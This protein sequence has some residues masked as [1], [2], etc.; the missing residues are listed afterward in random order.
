MP[1]YQLSR[2]GTWDYPTLGFRATN[3]DILIGSAAPDAFWLLVADG[4]AETVVRY[5]VG[6]GTPAYTE[7]VD[8]TLL[9]WNPTSK[10]FEQTTAA[11]YF[12]KTAPKAALNTG[13]AQVLTPIVGEAPAD[14][15]ARINAALAATSPFGTRKTVRLVGNFTI[16]GALVVPSNT[17]LDVLGATITASASHVGC[18]IRNAGA[19]PVATGTGSIAAGSQTLTTSLNLNV[20]QTVTIAGADG[21]GTTVHTGTITAVGAGSVTIDAAAK[22]TVAGATVLVFNRDSDVR[23]LHGQWNR[24][25]AA[26]TGTAPG[27]F[28]NIYLRHVD[29]WT[30]DI[31]GLSSTAAKYALSVGSATRGRVLLRGLQANSDGC[32][33]IGPA[34][35]IHVEL[36]QGST[37]DDVFAITAADWV[38]YGDTAGDVRNIT[39]GNIFGTSNAALF[40]V[41]SGSGYHVDGVKVLGEITGTA[42][43][44]GVYI[45]DDTGQ[46]ST[47]GGTYGDIDFGTL[48]ATA[49]NQLVVVN[50]M[51]SGESVRG[52]VVWKYGAGRL[53]RALRVYAPNS[54]TGSTAKRLKLL[55]LDVNID[56]TGTVDSTS[57]PNAV[58]LFT[59]D[60][61]NYT[62]DTIRLR[63]RFAANAIGGVAVNHNEGNV[64]EYIWELDALWQST[65]ATYGLRWY[66]GTISRLTAPRGSVVGGNVLLRREGAGPTSTLQVVLGSAFRASAMSRVL[67]VRTGTTAVRMDNPLFDSLLNA[68]IF[69]NGG[70]LD[71]DGRYA[72]VGSAALL[73]QGG[74]A[75]IRARS[76]ALDL[77][78]ATTGL[79]KNNGDMANNTNAGLSCG[80]GPA[81]SNGTAWKN[82]YSGAT[83]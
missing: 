37:G 77:D 44:N 18:L 19:F 38:A 67:D 27:R 10:A 83:Y 22:S 56:T 41:I 69:T 62:V 55:D 59:K 2:A 82:L 13:Y 8:G 50:G 46:P 60:G 29:D 57:T 81:V 25:S 71:L 66:L 72:K 21:A 32:H 53:D 31:A 76:A 79:A 12:A 15:T 65:T 3:G 20:G 51:D 24:G 11:A 5:G 4:P 47:T 64:G 52:R 78:L 80:A 7:P 74:T 33:I 40:K 70:I 75:A 45:G 39:I 14:T 6:S 48:N 34:R 42:R 35:D 28:H 26:F 43:T 36:L 63:G 16:E 30:V 68:A 23:I 54:G 49:Q 9:T 61:A 58:D 1:T 73:Q 17:V